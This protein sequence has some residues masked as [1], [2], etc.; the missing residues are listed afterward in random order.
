MKPGEQLLQDPIAW[1][2][3]LITTQDHD[4]LYP[5][6]ARWT[7][8]VGRERVKRYMVAYW[9][10]YSVGASWW[11]S[12]HE[13]RDFWRWLHCAALNEI[14]PDKVGACDAERWPRAH[15]RRHWRGQKCVDSVVWLAKRFPSPEGAVESLLGASS[16]RE[17]E[18]RIKEWPQFGPWIAFK[19]ADM[20]ER[21][22]GEPVTFPMDIITLY[23]DPRKAAE[24]AGRLWGTSPQA[25]AERVLGSL[26]RLNAPGLTRRSVNIQ[27]VET[28]L[29]KWKSAM[30]G[31]YWLG[32]D[33]QLHRAELHRWGAHDLLASYPTIQA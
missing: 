26:T 18:C 29:C 21:V 13:G 24:M 6:L 31:H 28:V 4:P 1:G 32:M 23:R 27:E 9:S 25:A 19:A 30:G 5:G 3:E 17:V 20:M 12:Q 10:C 15:E 2:E 22:L 7:D 14:G 33:T 16:L 11:I 8:T